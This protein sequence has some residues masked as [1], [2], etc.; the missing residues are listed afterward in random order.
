VRKVFEPKDEGVAGRTGKMHNKLLLL[1][2]LCYDGFGVVLE[3]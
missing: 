3:R 1:A 2:S